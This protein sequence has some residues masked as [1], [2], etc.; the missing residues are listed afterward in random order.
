M[1]QSSII[2]RLLSIVCAFAS[3][4]LIN[5]ALGLSLRGDYTTIFTYSNLLQTTLNFGIAFAY[6]PLKNTMGSSRAKACIMT[7]SWIQLMVYTCLALL[8]LLVD[9]SQN[10]FYICIL[11][12]S[13]V[14][15]GQVIFVALLD[16]I[17]SRNVILLIS[18]VFYMM[19][20]VAVL[21]FFSGNLHMVL[22][23]LA[24]KLAFETVACARRD[25]LFV[26]R[27]AELNWETLKKIARF[28]LPTAV[29]GLLIS[30]NYNIDV[31]I[32]NVLNSN[33]FEVG[34]FGVAYT[35]SNMLWFIPD[36]FK[37][38]VYHKSARGDIECVT[39]VLVAANMCICGLICIAFAIFGEQLLGLL[40]GEEYRTAFS[41]TMT[42]FIG[43]IPMIAF[44]L[45]H[46]IYVN[47]GKAPIVAKLLIFSVIA[48]VIAAF[49]LI[50]PHGAYGAALATVFSY[51]LCGFMF[52]IRFVKDYKITKEDCVIEF[53]K[54]VML[55]AK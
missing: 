20:N 6:A 44:K 48:N 23:L 26:L 31:V 45:I 18:A 25:R 30:C 37:E 39:M 36:A 10:N 46:P 15:N 14:I 17:R 8:F 34:V 47:A 49:I 22:A 4:I 52:T 51:S 9:F 54:I 43:I 27:S 1:V 11:T 32:L 7:V 33:S 13:L 41:T 16:D 53:K 40:Y 38:Y 3:S 29:L 50:P 19:A 42:V 28:G 12:M 21:L 55:L 24:A 35:L 2:I 5:R